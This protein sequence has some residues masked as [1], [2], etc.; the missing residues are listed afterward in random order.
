VGAPSGWPSGLSLAAGRLG[1]GAVQ[2]AMEA[3]GDLGPGVAGIGPLID[4]H[5][6]LRDG[7]DP[8]EVG[9]PPRCCLKKD[10][11]DAQLAAAVAVDHAAQLGASMRPAVTRAAQRGA[12]PPGRGAI[13]GHSGGEMMCTSRLIRG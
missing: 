5:A 10:W 13:C 8:A 1:D 4:G 11:L 12:W 2:G 3:E 6:A 9:G 7:R